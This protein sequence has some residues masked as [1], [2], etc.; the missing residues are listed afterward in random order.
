MAL[1]GVHVA[2]SKVGGFGPGAQGTIPLIGPAY[3]SE[4]LTS[5]GT[6]M[7]VAPS[8]GIEAGGTV[9]TV[10]TSAEAYVAIGANPNASTGARHH[11]AAGEKA[12]FFVN[13]GDKLAW[14]AA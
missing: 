10:R 4:T 14:I 11:L 12:Y 2:C 1:S 5:P 6:T 7:N 13:S 8:G 9:F 3:W